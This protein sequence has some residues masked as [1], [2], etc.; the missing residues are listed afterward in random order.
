M[1]GYHASV[2]KPES[3]TPSSAQA[4]TARM[5]STYRRRSRPGINLE[6]E[7]QERLSDRWR[8]ENGR[9]PE[10]SHRHTSAP[11]NRREIE[12]GLSAV[13]PRQKQ[14]RWRE[15]DDPLYREIAHRDRTGEAR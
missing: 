15:H 4:S 9:R 3:R 10:Q 14:R 12:I 11:R 6:P 7:V 2:L 5:I 13:Q 1:S 8:K